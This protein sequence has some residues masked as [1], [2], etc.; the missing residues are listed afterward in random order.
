MNKEFQINELL[1]DLP[2]LAESASEEV[3]NL[4][5]SALSRLLQDMDLAYQEEIDTLKQMLE[6]TE[7][8]V[9]QLEQALSE[10]E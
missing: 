5:K 10:A 9:Q 1:Q 2:E 4:I 6:R 7:Q 3:R 8:R